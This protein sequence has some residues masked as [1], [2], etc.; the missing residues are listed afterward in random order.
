MKPGEI[1]EAFLSY[2]DIGTQVYK[3]IVLLSVHLN[4]PLNQQDYDYIKW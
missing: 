4:T 1:S 2:N 3:I